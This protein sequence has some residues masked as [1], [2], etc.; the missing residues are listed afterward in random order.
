[1]IILSKYLYK[2]NWFDNI[3]IHILR[4]KFKVKMFKSILSKMHNHLYNKYKN[5]KTILIKD[6]FL[7]AS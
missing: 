1:M 5:K 7:N 3:K 4:P 2:V 6:R